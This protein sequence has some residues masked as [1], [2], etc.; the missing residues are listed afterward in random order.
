MSEEL[1]DFDCEHHEEDVVKQS[2]ELGDWAQIGGIAFFLRKEFFS[3]LIQAITD[4]LARKRHM[5]DVVLRLGNVELKRFDLL[6]EDI[7]SLRR[8]LI[9]IS[10]ERG[11]SE[12]EGE[13]G[14]NKT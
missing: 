5:P 8:Q 10:M 13:N 1:E 3:T 12:E 7:Q 6:R 4:I 14:K 9:E 11:W 2:E